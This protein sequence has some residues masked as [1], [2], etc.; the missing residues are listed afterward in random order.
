MIE[1]ENRVVRAHDSVLVSLSD[2]FHEAE[3]VAARYPDRDMCRKLRLS[4]RPLAMRL[5]IPPI[6]PTET[7]KSS[8]R[9]VIIVIR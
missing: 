8:K 7:W 5:S 2:D 6:M 3:F 9:V 4:R 1:G